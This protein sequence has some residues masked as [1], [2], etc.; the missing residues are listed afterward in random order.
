MPSAEMNVVA[1]LA[2]RRNNV[3]LIDFVPE[4]DMLIERAERVVSMAGYNTVCSLLSFQKI[5]LL[6]PRV[7]PRAEQRIRAERL[8]QLGFV[9]MMLPDAL[10]VDG[11]RQWLLRSRSQP[12]SVQGAVDFAGLSRLP[13]LTQA[14]I[15]SRSATRRP[16]SLPQTA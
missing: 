8:Q 2:A 4:A 14:L 16:L 11:L 7:A 10:T 9:D 1:E 13:G 5:A 15:A 6:V 12:P 3:H